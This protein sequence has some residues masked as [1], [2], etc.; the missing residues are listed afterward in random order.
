[1]HFWIEN[2]LLDPN[3]IYETFDWQL[4]DSVLFL[5]LRNNSIDQSD[6]LQISF[7]ILI[8]IQELL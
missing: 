3:C 7:L 5:I 8:S 1:M 6:D 2:A 4:I